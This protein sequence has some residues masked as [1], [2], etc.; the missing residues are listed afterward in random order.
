M[1]AP[2][3]VQSTGTATTEQ[4]E[5]PVRDVAR[6]F[7]AVA[8]DY[9]Q[10]GVAF[11]A[12]IARRLVGLVRVREGEDV[13]DVGCGRGAVTLAAAADTGPTG[14]VTAID[15]SPA[16]ARHTRR[17]AE[18]AG[19][20]HVRVEVTDAMRPALP[21]ESFDVLTSSLVLFFLPDPAVALSRWTRLLRPGGR[22]GATTFGAQDGTWQAVD[23]LF[24]PYLPPRLLD[25]RT[26]RADSPF[27]SDEGVERLV[28][29]AGVRDV[30][31]VR[32]WLPVRFRDA[33]QWRSWSMGTGQRAMWGCV[34]Q[35]DRP[36]LFERASALLE[37][38]RDGA[39]IVLQQEVRYTLA[40]V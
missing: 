2:L 22:L 31:T 23:R 10:S 9:D 40:R 35:D 7:D 21:P 13:L 38:A 28:G 8:D 29:R 26:G 39:D 20:D 34:P 32:E 19:L 1:T 6:T 30:R 12:P 4:D 24:H 11:F 37:G 14:S 5:D 25:P 36:G 33:E 16:M 15:V 3:S 18:A 17:A 27:A